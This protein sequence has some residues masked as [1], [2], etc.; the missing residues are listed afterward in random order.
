MDCGSLVILYLMA[1]LDKDSLSSV[2]NPRDNVA[3]RVHCILHILEPGVF[4]LLGT[5]NSRILHYLCSFRL[6][7][8]SKKTRL[9]LDG[10][11]F[12]VG[13]L[14]WVLKLQRK[15]PATPAGFE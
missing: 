6:S 2:S 14:L 4:R 12:I 10:R 3:C 15:H 5:C 1:A 9:D 7:S 13:P 8:E 11:Y